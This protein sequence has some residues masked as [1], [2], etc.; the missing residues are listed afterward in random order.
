[1]RTASGKPAE[2]T[3][4]LRSY[5]EGGQVNIEICDDGGGIDPER[6]KQKSIEKGILT[7]QQAERMGDRE[8]FNLI[9]QP[10]FS[11]AEKV[12]NVSG[13][14]VGMDVVKTNIEKIGGAIEIQ[15]K[16]G[17]GTTL[18]I[19]IPLTL[20]IIPALTVTSQGDRYAIPQI[21]LVELL[22]LEG[23]RANTEIESIHGVPVYRL[24]GN[25]LPLVYLNK[26]L[27]DE[28]GVS[29][30]NDGE[31]MVNIVVLQA[32]EQQFGLV[33]DEISDTQ[34]IVVKPLGKQ[35]KDIHCLAGS[36]IM[37]DGTVA[38]ILDAFGIAESANV[39]SEMVGEKSLETR[40]EKQQRTA[41]NRQ[42]LLLLQ[43]PDGGR[44]AAPLSEVAR[45]E[46]IPR[47]AVERV[48]EKRVVQ[49]RGGIIPLIDV[50]AT[51]PERRTKPRPV[52]DETLLEDKGSLQVVV[53][54]CGGQDVGLI[55]DK[56][57]DVID[58]A[59]EITGQSTR[60]GVLGT[61]VIQDRVTE[62]INIEEIVHMSNPNLR[63]QMAAALVA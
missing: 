54:A 57:L 10:G 9:F 38:L 22:L 34:E 3:L 24:R 19:K 32:G 36:T 52:E 7:A 13:R 39:L 50:F 2:G 51:L 8:A 42:M 46:D 29:Q 18:K 63:Q 26:V 20:A 30:G 27:W 55:V 33:V 37:G 31:P 6:L 12:T 48:G 41:A 49:Y 45:L 60:Q 56:I 1:V 58:E 35:L 17:E 25:L 15:S 44:M 61:A 11:T 53:Y 59:I 28:E 5:H 14:G 47:S 62:L 21:N 16:V 40:D 23:E 43:N 4:L